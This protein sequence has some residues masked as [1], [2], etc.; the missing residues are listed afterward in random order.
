ME[1]ERMR[2]RERMRELIESETGTLDMPWH[3]IPDEAMFKIVIAIMDMNE[4]LGRT[5]FTNKYLSDV[6]KFE[7]MLD[8]Y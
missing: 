3:L 6:Q 2:L 8:Q 1:E 5:H 4:S 7:E